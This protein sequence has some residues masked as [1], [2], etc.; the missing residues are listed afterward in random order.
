MKRGIQVE[1]PQS[2]QDRLDELTVLRDAALDAA[3]ATQSRINLLPEDAEG[4]LRQRLADDLNRHVRCQNDFHRLLSACNQFLMQLRLAPGQYLA[5]VTI[6]GTPPEGQTAADAIAHI[7]GLIAAL[8]RKISET[9][10]APLKKSSRGEA[11]GKYL[12]MLAQRAKPRIG[13]DQQGNARIQFVEDIA[14]MDTTVGLLALCFPQELA[15]VLEAS[16]GEGPADA[17][18]AVTPDERERQLAR[19]AD[20][21]LDLERKEVAL[22]SLAE[23]M[24]PR[25][26][27]N[28]MAY[29]QIQIMAAEAEAAV[30]D[31]NA[32]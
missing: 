17:P 27:T 26:E 6:A 18:N 5:P 22:L 32:A 13:F 16:L 4:A 24:L 9:K 11:I 15:T 2:A 1:V 3:K 19:L 12:G 20:E 29:L 31:A 8:N 30:A 25:P 21:L 14:T 28:P 7:R 10:R 23:G